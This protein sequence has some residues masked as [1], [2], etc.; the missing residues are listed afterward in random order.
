MPTN[1]LK[2]PRPECYN[3]FYTAATQRGYCSIRCQNLHDQLPL[4]L[5]PP[6]P[7]A[8]TKDWRDVFM[9]GKSR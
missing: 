7:D 5:D 2:C 9:K 1:S 6:T 3:I 4:P 8:A